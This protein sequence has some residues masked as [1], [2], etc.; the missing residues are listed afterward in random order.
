MS[1]SHTPSA[2]AV[3]AATNARIADLENGL[4]ALGSMQNPAL[5]DLRPAFDAEN[6]IALT[7]AFPHLRRQIVTECVEVIDAMLEHWRHPM[8][9]H[10]VLSSA[11][12]NLRA[13]LN[14]PTK[15]GDDA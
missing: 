11:K 9:G 13:L 2:E 3:E 15:E 5:E 12:Y 1:D 6:T 4:R 7:A 10:A 8:Q 14:A